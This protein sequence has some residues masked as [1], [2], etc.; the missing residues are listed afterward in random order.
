MFAI[1]LNI[2][3]RMI[4]ESF[5]LISPLP[6]DECV[7]RLGKETGSKWGIFHRAPVT[8]YVKK[9]SLLLRKNICYRNHFQLCLLG[10]FHEENGRT[11]LRCRFGWEPFTTAS[12]IV[13]WSGLVLAAIATFVAWLVGHELIPDSPVPLFGVLLFCFGFSFVPMIIGR[14]LAY[15]EPKFLIAFL[16]RTIDARE[17]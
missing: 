10:Q 15:N 7:R 12:M 16:R 8:G 1:I 11:R 13:V 14:W 3:D 6:R 5:D 17:A 2:L 9:T 4:S